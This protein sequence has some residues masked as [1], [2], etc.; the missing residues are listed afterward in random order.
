M[1]DEAKK[2]RSIGTKR[3]ILPPLF[4]VMMRRLEEGMVG[5]IPTSLE[6]N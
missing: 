4:P 6:A 2:M 5:L 3:S 1:A